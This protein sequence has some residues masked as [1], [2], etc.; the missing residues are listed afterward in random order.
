MTDTQPETIAGDRIS[1]GPQDQ[2]LLT[3]DGV[4]A[5]S[6]YM[7]GTPFVDERM[8]CINVYN[9]DMLRKMGYENMSMR[10]AA[11]Q[12]AKDNKP[13]MIRFMLRA[14]TPEVKQAYLEQQ[15]LID[16]GEGQA[17]DVLRDLMEDYKNNARPYDETVTRIMCLVL[18]MRIKFMN[19]WKDTVP[20]LRIDDSREP[21]E[22]T[23]LGGGREVEM[24][25]FKFISVNASEATRQRMGL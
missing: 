16:D 23:G 19:G 4:L 3:G 13:G 1:F 5:F 24:G 11:T 9:A 18:K 6:L 2:P 17:K 15:K 10:E 22:T 21:R 12:A 20:L 14:P 25:G 8:W 7:A